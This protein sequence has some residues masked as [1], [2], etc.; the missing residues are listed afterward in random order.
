MSVGSS[1]ERKTL[2]KGFKLFW[3]W[4]LEIVSWRAGGI[5]FEEG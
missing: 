5:A 3:K 2:T 1:F 4:K